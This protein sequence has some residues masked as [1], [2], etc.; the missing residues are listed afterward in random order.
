MEMYGCMAVICQ[1]RDV[2]AQPKTGLLREADCVLAPLGALAARYGLPPKEAMDFYKDKPGV[3]LS[4]FLDA[5]MHGA[6]DAEETKVDKIDPRFVAPPVG[7]RG[8]GPIEELLPELCAR[9]SFRI[10]SL[11][12]EDFDKVDEVV[13]G[14]QVPM[15]MTTHE[16]SEE[17]SVR[18]EAERKIP[19]SPKPRRSTP[20]KP[21]KLAGKENRQQV[22]RK[23]DPEV[24]AKI[25]TGRGMV[26]KQMAVKK[27]VSATPK[28]ECRKTPRVEQRK[29]DKR[30][31]QHRK[32]D[33]D[34]GRGAPPQDEAR[35]CQFNMPQQVGA[36]PAEQVGMPS[37]LTMFMQAVAMSRSLRA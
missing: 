29:C 12:R 7:T 9:A 30:K 8:G 15:D 20:E 3:R 13:E 25:G 35:Y 31:P 34:S 18:P 10:P 2:A 14:T 32:V 37:E 5:P 26:P 27:K 23:I 22:S 1:E 28:S 24:P 36:P 6:P 17:G 21:K 16:S 19:V 11:I 4:D 33:V